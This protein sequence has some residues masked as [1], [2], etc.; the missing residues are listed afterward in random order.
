[1][2]IEV[3]NARMGKQRLGEAQG[4]R[5]FFDDPVHSN[6]LRDHFVASSNTPNTKLEVT[7]THLGVDDG[8]IEGEFSADVSSLGILLHIVRRSDGPT[9]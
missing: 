4:L 8:I 9:G 3:P 5:L 2:S 1:M 7:L 6:D